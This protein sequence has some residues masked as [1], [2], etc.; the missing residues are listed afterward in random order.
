MGLIREPLTIDLEIA[1]TN[2]RLR[3]SAS[4]FIS[5]YISGKNKKN[6]AF[7]K[8]NKVVGSIK[9]RTSRNRKRL[10]GV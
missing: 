2:Q 4:A 3:D 8:S 10:V 6:L 1:P 5:A 9:K 7:R